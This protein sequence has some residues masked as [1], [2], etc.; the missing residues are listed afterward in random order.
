MGAGSDVF[1]D[2]A[3]EVAAGHAVVVEEDVVAMLGEV[4]EDCQRPGSVGA[5]VA[6]EDCLFDAS[7]G[8]LFS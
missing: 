5:A 6:D 3:L 8:G 1:E 2:D 4:L 7:H